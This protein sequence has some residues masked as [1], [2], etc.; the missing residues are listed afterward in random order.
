MPLFLA[1][2]F[3][4][5]ALLQAGCEDC[6]SVEPAYGGVATDEAWRV[7]VDARAAAV[8]GDQ[9]AAVTFP[10]EG[11]A[12]SQSND[13]AALTWESPLK[14]AL[15]APSSMELRAGRH[16][17]QP[18]LLDALS[19]ALLPRALAHLPPVTSDLHFVEVDVPGRTCPVSG[20]TT[21][22][23]FL[24]DDED[25]AA[26]T[27]EAGERTLRI[28]SAFLTE[29]RITEGPFTGTPVSFTVVQ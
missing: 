16:R 14:T 2:L 6:S 9:A 26:I 15:W 20:L 23:S 1:V 7:M 11:T 12:L 19:Q 17:H 22:E 27:G 5:V 10:V 25:W 29:N 24:F 21:E 18:G 4:V 28:M 3:V 13:A 8:E